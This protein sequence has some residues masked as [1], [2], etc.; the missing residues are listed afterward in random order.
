MD[1]PKVGRPVRRT[2]LVARELARFH[3]DIAALGETRIANEGQL[4]EDGGGYCFFWSGR[5]SEE[6]RDAGVGFAIRPHLVSNIASLPI[7]LNYRTAHELVI[8][9][10]LFRLSTRNKTTWMDASPI[11]ALASDWLHYHKE[12]RCKWRQ[13]DEANV[14]GR[15]LDWPPTIGVQAHTTH[16]KQLFKCHPA[17]LQVSQW[18]PNAGAWLQ[19]SW[20]AIGQATIEED[21]VVLRDKIHETAIQLLGPTTRKKTGLVWWKW[22]RNQENASR[23]ESSSQN[24]PSG[25]IICSQ[26]DSFH[27]HS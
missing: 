27:Q 6:W 17:Q 3:V 8:T 23:K 14:W 22:W 12:E 21:W 1:N 11:K 16:P 2:A 4:T 25:Q 19:T 20:G 18:G 7:C 13:S 26:K 10:T 15:V 24:L 9:N 5:T